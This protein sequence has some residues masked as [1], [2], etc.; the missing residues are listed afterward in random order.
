M[1]VG[2]DQLTND[3]MAETEVLR[4][5]LVGLPDT[6][7]ELATPAEGWAVRDQ[8]SHL[9]YFDDA[10][11]QSATDPDAFQAELAK[12]LAGGGLSP[13]DIA[14]RTATCRRTGCS[15]GSTT[16][17]A[18]S[19]PTLAACCCARWKRGRASFA[20]LPVVSRTFVIWN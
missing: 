14:A 19:L 20:T 1:P 16:T 4:A 13:D 17:A 12:M 8:I 2:M 3:L 11:V 5:L 18:R 9:A 10:A 7:W 15:P 6:D